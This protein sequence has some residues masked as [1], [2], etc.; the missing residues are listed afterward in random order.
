[1]SA[2]RGFDVATFDRSGITATEDALDRE[3]ASA[4][5]SRGGDHGASYARRG[6]ALFVRLAQP[7]GLSKLPKSV[8]LF[9][10]QRERGVARRRGEFRAEHVAHGQRRPRPG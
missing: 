1:M 2:P 7:D 8:R 6:R 9:D 10:V 5:T 4:F 3:T